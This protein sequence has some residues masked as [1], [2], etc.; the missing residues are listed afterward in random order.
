VVVYSRFHYH[1][2]ADGDFKEA[3]DMIRNQI[4]D[5]VAWMPNAKKSAIGLVVGKELL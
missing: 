1:L 5:Q 2:I 3:I 4:I